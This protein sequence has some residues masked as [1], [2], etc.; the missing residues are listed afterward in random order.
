[1]RWRIATLAC[2]ALALGCGRTFNAPNESN[3]PLQALA[4]PPTVAPLGTATITI[5]GGH[6]NVQARLDDGDKLSGPA[7]SIAPGPDARTFVYTAGDQGGV[8][9]TVRITD[10]GS[11]NV[12]VVI[13][14]S[15]A[16]AVSPAFLNIGPGQQ[17]PLTISGGHKDY[18]LS[19]TAEPGSG[20]A[21]PDP[22]EAC[23]RGTTTCTDGGSAAC[24]DGDGTLHA[25]RCGPQVL[26]AHVRDQNHA[27]AQ[28][29][30]NVGSSLTVEPPELTLVPGASERLAVFGGVAPYHFSL[31]A[32]GN[33]S[34]GSIDPDGTYHSGQNPLVDDWIEIDD[35]AGNSAAVVAHVT[36][37]TF[38]IQTRDWMWVLN[39]DFNGDSIADTVIFSVAFDGQHLAR[40]TSFFGD[41]GG[42]RAGPVFEVS[43]CG[44]NSQ[45]IPLAVDL[46]GDSRADIVLPLPSTDGSVLGTG[47][48]LM[49]LKGRADSSFDTV[50]PVA[51]PTTSEQ[52]PGGVSYVRSG[53]QN[54]IAI[55]ELEGT[56]HQMLLLRLD[57]QAGLVDAGAVP[58]PSQADRYTQWIP[59][60]PDSQLMPQYYLFEPN[61]DSTTNCGASSVAFIPETLNLPDG[62][63]QTAPDGGLMLTS[64]SPI[65]LPRP[66]APGNGVV[67]DPVEMIPTDIHGSDAVD[68]V[69]AAA[70]RNNAESQ[71]GTLVAAKDDGL[72]YRP[73]V[74][75]LGPQNLVMVVGQENKTHAEFDVTYP[76]SG[77]ASQRLILAPDGGIVSLAPAL[78]SGT[79]AVGVG[80]FDYD[81][82]ADRLA[83]DSNGVTTFL[84]ESITG[85]FGLGHTRVIPAQAQ[86]AIAPDVNGDGIADF[87]VLGEDGGSILWG[88]PTSDG[89]AV[90]PSFGP[91]D[92]QFFIAAPGG[93]V[94]VNTEPDGNTLL[95]WFNANVDGGAATAQRIPTQYSVN[96]IYG[97]DNLRAGGV[98]DG[99]DLALTFVDP[100]GGPDQELIATVEG[101]GGVSFNDVSAA[102]AGSSDLVVATFVG[103]P[104]SGA[105]GLWA[106]RQAADGSNYVE[107]HP[108]SG[109]G[110]SATPSATVQLDYSYSPG[111]V[112]PASFSATPGGPR[113]HLAIIGYDDPS[114]CGDAELYIIDT[115]HPGNPQ[116]GN[117]TLACM[118]GPF[119][120]QVVASDLDGDGRTDLLG[121][122][123]QSIFV[124]WQ[125]PDGTFSEDDDLYDE[126]QR[127][128][129]TLDNM[130][131][132]FG[133][134]D[135]D[136]LMDIALVSPD[137]TEVDL[138][139][140]QGNR[141]FW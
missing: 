112:N 76:G 2:C 132:T 109:T 50:G 3:Q 13:N 24:I 86:F 87:F 71:N 93:L 135:G 46:D 95:G 26:T 125:N 53:A 32:R 120:A 54:L 58:L 79:I 139:H 57:P 20:C 61:A 141:Q 10:E 136:G 44:F 22:S 140:N 8:A 137:S 42:P 52:F 51:V 69:Y 78:P 16:L 111:S 88:T 43:S 63:L 73:G 34:N 27:Q 89:L 82:E 114:N 59:G 77:Q 94:A 17:F 14:V 75:A 5:T 15:A 45:G 39:A 80:D 48:G 23:G 127:R 55:P 107:L 25:A 96:E 30:A 100:A 101:D 123:G 99:G 7:A 122:D 116:V 70:D 47:L 64:G 1:M 138:I 65:C 68:L 62:G 18:C 83:I 129:Q 106:L 40:V 98:V 37:P 84:H 11:G 28:A 130:A 21:D 124:M 97:L 67:Y 4:S 131:P 56:P 117:A 118:N 12:P 36:T 85:D 9:D 60:T 35:S 29:V 103:G 6:G 92:A 110:L 119:S 66:L 134:F 81:G 49:V 126:L 41:F 90:G 104:A 38:Q 121:F 19:L 115:Q 105:D 31:Q 113:D 108:A 91:I 133:D 102:L 33:L 128:T 74:H 72:G